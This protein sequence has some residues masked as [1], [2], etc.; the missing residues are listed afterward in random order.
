MT[1]GFDRLNHRDSMTSSTTSMPWLVHTYSTFFFQTVIMHLF[2]M[3]L[4][5]SL[6]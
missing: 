4:Q 3:R 5:Q 2:N 6:G 1:G